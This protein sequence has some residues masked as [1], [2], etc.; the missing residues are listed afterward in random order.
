MKTIAFGIQK[1]G[2]GKTTL[3]GN[4]AFLLASKGKKVCYI[5]ADPQG[6]ASNW[7]FTVAP[8]YELADVLTGAVELAKALVEIR[9]NL[10]MLP[11]FAIN[12][13]L[14]HYSES[15]L[16]KE[17]FVFMDLIEAIKELGFDYAVY[18]TSPGFGNLERCVYYS[19]D[20]VCCPLTPE[21][22]SLD[23]IESFKHEIEQVNKQMTR[24][25]KSITFEKII[26]NN[27]NNSFKTHTDMHTAFVGMNFNAFT[28]QQDRKVADS[29]I[30]KKTIFEYYPESKTIPE[31]E[32]F[33][34]ALL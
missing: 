9:P 26:I 4:T 10:F 23:G 22:F 8:Q 32:R 1:G 24:L 17:Q 21:I 5:D 30:Y 34:S 15:N 18:D 11:T 16:F 31:F 6:S 33:V 2:V 12:G 7:F 27:K 29:Q 13:Q 19:A 3:S 25:K 28:I 20:E 14:K